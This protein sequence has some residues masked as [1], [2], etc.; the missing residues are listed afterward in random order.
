MS[1]SGSPFVSIICFLLL[2]FIFSVYG[3]IS[4]LLLAR[5]YLFCFLILLLHYSISFT[6]FSFSLCL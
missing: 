3:T 5:L 2:Y 4:F 1:T 6:A